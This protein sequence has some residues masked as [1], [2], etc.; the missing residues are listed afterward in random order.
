MLYILGSTAEK[1][2]YP[3]EM[4]EVIVDLDRNCGDIDSFC[5]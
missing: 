5:I 4:E 1:I 2:R 3:D